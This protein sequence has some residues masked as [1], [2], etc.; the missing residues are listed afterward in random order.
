MDPLTALAAL[1][2]LGV[3]LGKAAIS[4]W[5]AP[6]TFK[7]S[8]ID[9]W[10]RMREADTAAFKALADAG[11]SEA[12]Y[13]WVGAVKQLMRPFIAAIVL[14][15]WA[16]V[17]LQGG[18]DAAAVVMVDNFAATVGFYLFGDRTLFLVQG[19][20]NANSIPTPSPR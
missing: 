13:L 8:S 19:S 6:D 16:T 10:L 2:P 11:G 1:A 4:R 17:H 15:V 14:M 9:E 5:V 7:P 12:T 20:R 3:E 18:M